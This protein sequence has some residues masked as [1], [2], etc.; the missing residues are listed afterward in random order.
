MMAPLAVLEIPLFFLAWLVDVEVE[1]VVVVPEDW[2]V[3]V[4]FTSFFSVVVS[5]A[6]VSASVCVAGATITLSVIAGAAVAVSCFA[7]LLPQETINTAAGNTKR[8]FI[9]VLVLTD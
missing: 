5:F 3:L 1:D 9:M 8:A 6:C 4:R 2:L 7:L